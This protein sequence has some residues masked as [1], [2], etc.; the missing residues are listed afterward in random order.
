MKE[1][2]RQRGE[3]DIWLQKKKKNKDEHR[4]RAPLA[5]RSGLGLLSLALGLVQARLVQLRGREIV[6]QRVAV[7]QRENPR[8]VRVALNRAA[9][10]VLHEWR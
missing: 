9:R 8:A 5:S 6:L 1:R 10:S 4:T 3:T 7:Q 2:N